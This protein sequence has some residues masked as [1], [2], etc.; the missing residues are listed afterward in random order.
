MR[1]SLFCFLK[2]GEAYLANWYVYSIGSSLKLLMLGSVCKITDWRMH[3]PSFKFCIV[4]YYGSP[5][6]SNV[7]YRV[8]VPLLE[9]N[10]YKY[11]ILFSFL[12]N[13]LVSLHPSEHHSDTHCTRSIE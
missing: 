12:I 11:G 6:S 3:K 7:V 5:Y 9:N 10:V 8:Q 13:S 4:C 1:D 2:V